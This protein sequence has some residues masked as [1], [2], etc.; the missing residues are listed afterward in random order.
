MNHSDEKRNTFGKK[1]NPS[2]SFDES[3]IE[4]LKREIETIQAK[5]MLEMS[6]LR[7][8]TEEKMESIERTVSE[9]AEKYEELKIR[10]SLDYKLSVDTMVNLTNQITNLSQILM[11]L[12][13]NLSQFQGYLKQIIEDLQI[14]LKDYFALI[15]DISIR[16]E[17]KEELVTEEEPVVEEEPMI[18]EELVTVEPVIEEEPVVEEELVIEEE[19]MIEDELKKELLRIRD[20]LKV[21]KKK[22]EKSKVEEKIPEE[23]SAMDEEPNGNEKSNN[24]E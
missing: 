21:N 8:I 9:I 13:S 3:T 4:S 20:V 15:E 22:L 6:T 23:E 16:L 18:E 11:K 10:S 2:T 12:E 7:D 1:D 24:E 19:P 14:D 17:R 5:H